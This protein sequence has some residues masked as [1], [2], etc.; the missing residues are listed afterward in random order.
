MWF[1]CYVYCR[2]PLTTPEVQRLLKRGSE[3]RKL[4]QRLG[5]TKGDYVNLYHEGLRDKEGVV[6]A[7]VLKYMEHLDFTITDL[8]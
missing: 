4:L 7:Q 8:R 2:K 3:E 5:V 6:I 1:V